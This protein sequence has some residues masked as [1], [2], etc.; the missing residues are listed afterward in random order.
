MTAQ[1]HKNYA[2]DL[3]KRATICADKEMRQR[4]VDLAKE[5]LSHYFELT[6]G[7]DLAF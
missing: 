5:H 3:F 7:V 1:D 6:K 4:L 2:Q